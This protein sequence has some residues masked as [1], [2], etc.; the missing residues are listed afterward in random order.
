MR[1]GVERSPAHRAFCSSGTRHWA[2]PLWA[3]RPHPQRRLT[4]RSIKRPA[5]H[6][7]GRSRSAHA[8]WALTAGRRIKGTSSHGRLPARTS[9][10]QTVRRRAVMGWAMVRWAVMGRTVVWRTIMWRTVMRRPGISGMGPRRPLPSR[11]LVARAAHPSWTMRPWSVHHGASRACRALRPRSG[12]DIWRRKSSFV[13]R[14]S[15]FGG[16]SAGLLRVRRV[17]GSPTQRGLVRTLGHLPLVCLP[18]DL[19]LLDERL[20]ELLDLHGQTLPPSTVVAEG[21]A[22]LPGRYILYDGGR[23]PGVSVVLQQGLGHGRRG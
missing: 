2:R 5:A 15:R 23:I 7:A 17:R 11:A 8:G 3:R 18:G 20:L 16:C 14:P 13:H 19:L 1:R 6:G 9:L 10:H 12:L 4:R 22:V 21:E